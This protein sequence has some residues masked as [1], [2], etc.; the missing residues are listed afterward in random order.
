M[1]PITLGLAA[2]PSIVKLFAGGSQRRKAGKLVKDDFTSPSLERMDNKLKSQLLRG[3][4]KTKQAQ[5]RKIRQSAS[6]T[7]SNIK[8]TVKSPADVVTSA[9]Q[10]GGAVSKM[11]AGV[12]E[13]FGQRQE[14][15]ERRRENVQFAKARQEE[16]AEREFNRAKGA[17]IG[18]GQQNIFGG[19][20]GLAT[21]GV[22]AK[23]GGKLS[24]AMTKDFPFS[25]APQMFNGMTRQQIQSAINSG[26]FARS[27]LSQGDLDWLNVNSFDISN[28]QNM[29]SAL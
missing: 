22:T 3:T 24:D 28:I 21:V 7:I 11:Q 29:S 10:I 13:S 6:D 23:E 18:A 4:D 12:E 9:A 1:D 14:G 2:I 16:Q 17:L 19:L 26:R 20:T 25:D 5:E 27:N 8:K 15:R